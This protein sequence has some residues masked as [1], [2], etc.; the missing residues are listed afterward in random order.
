MKKFLMFFIFHLALKPLIKSNYRKRK[1]GLEPDEWYW[2][3]SL[4]VRY[5]YFVNAETN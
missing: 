1:E 5:G 4:A 3:D 2:A